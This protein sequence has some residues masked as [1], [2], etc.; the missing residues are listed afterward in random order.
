MVGESPDIEGWTVAADSCDEVRQL[1]ADGV[2]VEVAS[3]VEDRGD[4]FEEQIFADAVEHHIP[5][6]A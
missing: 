2:T 5:G 1:V 6:P 4:A 3:A